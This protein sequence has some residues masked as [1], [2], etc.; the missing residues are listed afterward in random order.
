MKEAPL[1]TI[2]EGDEVGNTIAD[3]AKNG[4][5]VKIC[6]E[7]NDQGVKDTFLSTLKKADAR[8]DAPQRVKQTDLVAPPDRKSGGAVF[9]LPLP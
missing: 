7:V 5:P 2:L 1:N 4:R 9:I 8:R 3:P 6:L